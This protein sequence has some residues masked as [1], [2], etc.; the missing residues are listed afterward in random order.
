MTA[1]R[2][3]KNAKKKAAFTVTG[4]YIVGYVTAAIRAVGVIRG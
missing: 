2:Y 1:A 4:S 3:V